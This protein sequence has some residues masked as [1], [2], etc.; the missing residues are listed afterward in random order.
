[1]KI[2]ELQGSTIL[3]VAE[4]LST[5]DTSLD[6]T[7]LEHMRLGHMSERGTTVLSNQGLLGNLVVRR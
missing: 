3:V 2:Y 7:C 5:T 6:I 1:M 4:V